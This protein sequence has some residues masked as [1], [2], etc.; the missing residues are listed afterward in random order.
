[1]QN[2]DTVLY[3]QKSRN[4]VVSMA[5]MIRGL[6]AGRGKIFQSQERLDKLWGPSSLNLC[7]IPFNSHEFLENELRERR[8]MLEKVK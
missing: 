2:V 4:S 6:I 8:T 7:I 3:E 1:M 5:W